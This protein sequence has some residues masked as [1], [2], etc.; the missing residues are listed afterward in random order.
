[1]TLQTIIVDTWHSLSGGRPQPSMA[2][3]LNIAVAVALTFVFAGQAIAQDTRAGVIENAQADRQ[4][5]LTPPRPNRAERIITRLQD[6]GLFAGAPRGLYTMDRFGVPGSGLTFGAGF[7]QVFADDGAVNT[8][9]A[10]S[11]SQSSRAEV[12][13]ALPSFA[14]RRARVT[15]YGQYIDAPEVK[16]FGIGNT[17]QRGDLT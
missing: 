4:R 16:F 6:W 17:S 15:L 3:G 13:V 8:M 1:M 14:R 11:A 2:L 9:G 12:E 10:Y 5:V 7:R